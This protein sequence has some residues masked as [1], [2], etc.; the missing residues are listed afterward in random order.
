MAEIEAAKQKRERESVTRLAWMKEREERILK[1][2]KTL[3][4]QTTVA[5]TT[6]GYLFTYEYTLIDL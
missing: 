4:P 3:R 1:A 6:Q 5:T 2:E